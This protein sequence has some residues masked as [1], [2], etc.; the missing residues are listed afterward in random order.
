MLMMVLRQTSHHAS[1]ENGAVLVLFAFF[2]PVAI[3]LVALVLDVGN[4]FEHKRH[5]QLQADAGASAAAQDF[6]YPCTAGGKTKLYKTAGLYGGAQSTITPEGKVDTFSEAERK[7]NKQLYNTQVGSTSQE[8]IHYEI[9]KKT[10]YG[11]ASQGQP[12]EVTTVEQAPCEAGMIDVKATET[13][14]PWLFQAFNVK[15]INAHARVSILQQ[16]TATGVSPLAVEASAPTTAKAYFINEDKPTEILASEKLEQKTNAQGEV[17]TNAQGQEVWSNSPGVP[18]PI[19][20][21]H[22]GVVVAL[23]GTASGPT[24]PSHAYVNCF[25]EKPGP[26]LLHIQGWSALGAG[27]VTSPLAREVTLSTPKPDTCTGE[28]L[29]SPSAQDC[30]FAIS[31]R[32]AYGGPETTEGSTE[33]AGITVTPVLKWTENGK[34]KKRE[35]GQLVHVK[36]SGKEFWTSTLNLPH[37]AGSVEINLKVKCAKGA[38]LCPKENEEGTAEDVQRIYAASASTSGTIEG[39][40]ISTTQGTPDSFEV[41]EAGH[42]ECT[43]TLNVTV[44]VAGALANATGFES[45]LYNLK[46]GAGEA[47]V[48]GCVPPKEPSGSKYRENLEEGC[49]YQYTLNTSEPSCPEPYVQPYNCVGEGRGVQHGPFEQGLNDRIVCGGGKFQKEIWEKEKK[50]EVA[51]PTR[52]KFYCPSSWA[53]NNGGAVPNLPRDDSRIVQVFVEPYGSLAVG[54]APIQNFATF[55]VTWWE[56]DPCG[57]DKQVT[58]GSN[59]EGHFIKYVAPNGNGEPEKKCELNSLGSCVATLTE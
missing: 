9:N 27:K 42:A 43:P 40:S 57:S 12:S 6:Q 54:A 33:T 18:V 34:A 55:Y 24:C 13:E 7:E 45:H 5:L 14:L 44:D 17:E 31:A 15:N 53:N 41:C 23:G 58:P 29:S 19:T 16:S 52:L 3:L 48:I 21:P 10:Y 11:Q 38:T 49:Q 51:S 36:A 2:T 50:C 35:E 28:Y 56:G 25:D 22:I 1:D 8:N 4:W 59:I 39:A 30:T 37:E 46:L 47:N 32:I 20:K 26:S